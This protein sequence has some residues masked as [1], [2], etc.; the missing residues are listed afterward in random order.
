MVLFVVGQISDLF[1]YLFFYKNYPFRDR[2]GYVPIY[3]RIESLYIRRA[4]TYIEDCFNRPIC[5]YPSKYIDVVDREYDRATKRVTPNGKTVRLLNLGSYNYLGLATGD[6]PTIEKVLMSVDTLPISLA[7]SLADVG[8]HGVVKELESAFADFLHQEDCLV[9]PMGFATNTCTI[10]VLTDVGDLII[11]DEYNHSSII[12]GSRL[13][14]ACVKTFPHNNVRELEKTLRYWISQGQP[15]SHKAWRRVFVLTEGIYSMEGTILRLPEIL[16]LK[17]RYKFYLFI[18][19]AH[20]VGAMGATGRGICEY[21][22]ADFRDVDILMGTFSK[23][24]NGVGGYIAGSRRV[25]GFLRQR[26]DATRYGEQL[27]PVVAKQV[28]EALRYLQSEEGR[29][30]PGVLRENSI[31]MRERLLDMGYVICGTRDSPVIPLMICTPGKVGEFSRL[32]KERGLAVVI[33]GHPATSVFT[34]RARL[35]MSAL[36]GRSDIDVAIRIID[37]VGRILGLRASRQR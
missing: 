29:R 21:F 34:C 22:G 16:E 20:S 18:D 31:Y 3:S 30:L 15:V 35:C 24:F 19:E 23:S 7:G 5:G 33:V 26:C 17:R 25:V 13:S 36:F 8:A 27:S 28:L 2:D 11:S 12:Y 9:F 1:T 6:S 32:C 10:P 14:R 37:D 4:Y